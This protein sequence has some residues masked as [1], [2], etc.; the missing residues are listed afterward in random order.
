LVDLVSS[1]REKI[2]E[3]KGELKARAENGMAEVREKF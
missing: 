3:V 2:G 1:S